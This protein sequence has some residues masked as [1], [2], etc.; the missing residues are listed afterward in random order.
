M[1]P[2]TSAGNRPVI[3]FDVMGTLVHNPFFKEIPA[4]FGCTHAELLQR[5]DPAVWMQFE[6]GEITQAEYLRRCYNGRS[7][8]TAAF[9]RCI[10]DAYSWLSGMEE[11]T[12]ELHQLGYEIHAFSNYP[13]WFRVIED[14]LRLSRYLQWTLVSCKTRV[15]KPSPEAFSLA[16]RTIGRPPASCF[17]IDDMIENCDGARDAGM[18]AIHFSGALA[19]RR[20]LVQLGI[21]PAA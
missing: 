4:F 19:L 2:R 14:K 16:L 11:Q 13:E 21:L 5:R 1:H 15:R 9:L 20:E 10:R 17:L 6:Q 7:F 3:L 12:R 18:R 8:D